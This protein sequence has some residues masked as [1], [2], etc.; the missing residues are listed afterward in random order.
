MITQEGGPM[1][2]L[3]LTSYWHK[4]KRVHFPCAYTVRLPLQTLKNL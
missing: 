2:N 1:V 3:D 4:D